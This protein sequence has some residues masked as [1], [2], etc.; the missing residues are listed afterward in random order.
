M[1]E[2]DSG[3]AREIYVV[4]AAVAGSITSLGFL[5]LKTMSRNQ[6]LLALFTSFSFSYFFGPVVVRGVQSWGA[7]YRTQGALFWLLATGS[8]TFISLAIKWGSRLF[9]SQQEQPK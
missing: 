7:D 1:V 4:L 9:G 5:S 3:M 8:N 2:H 6:I